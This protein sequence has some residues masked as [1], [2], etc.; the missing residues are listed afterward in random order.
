MKIWE[1]ILIIAIIAVCGLIAGYTFGYAKMYVKCSEKEPQVVYVPKEKIVHDTV[2]NIQYKTRYID[3]YDT[4]YLHTV[5]TV[6][7][8]D[9]VQVVIPIERVT[10]DTLTADSVRVKGSISGYNP[11]LDTLTVEVK[12]IENNIVIQEKK[13]GW[14]WGFGFALGFGYVK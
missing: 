1:K 11:S 10:F 8:S 9:T 2:T 6:T 14:H 12:T 7:L 13:S 4:T 5:D 3:H